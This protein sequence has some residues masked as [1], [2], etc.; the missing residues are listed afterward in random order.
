MRKS[1]HLSLAAAS[2]V[3]ATSVKRAT[4][5]TTIHLD[6]CSRSPQLFTQGVLHG[7]LGTATPP[8]SYVSDFNINY[9]SAGGAQVDQQSAG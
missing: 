3:Q 4:D 8:Q 9:E 5:T 2:T 7:I 1:V 6:Q